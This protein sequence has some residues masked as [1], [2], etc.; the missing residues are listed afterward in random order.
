MRSQLHIPRDLHTRHAMSETPRSEVRFLTLVLILAERWTLIAAALVLATA[1]GLGLALLLPARYTA[2]VTILPPQQQNSMLTS[3]LASEFGGLSSLAS[4]A[5]GGLG[6]KNQND[7]YVSMFKSRIVEDALI[8]R[9]NLQAEYRKKYLSDARK[10]FEKRASVEGGQKDGLIHIAFE[11]H[12]PGRAAQIAN[13]YVDQFRTLSQHLAITEASQRR[14]FLQGQ[15]DQ[16]KQHLADAEEAMKNTEQKTGL[17]ALDSQARALIESAAYLR[18]QIAA[19]Q[20]QIEAMR[21]YATDQNAGLAQAQQELTALRAQMQKLTGSQDVDGMIVPRGQVTEAG[22]EY[23][24]KMR[25]VKYYETE[26]ALLSKQLELARL[27]EAREGSL[28]QIV[29]PASPPDKR[30]FPHR[31]L[32]VLAAACAGLFLGILIALLHARFQRMNA[33]PQTRSMMERIRMA[34]ARRQVPL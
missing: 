1:I 24:R 30:S 18:A 28:I 17:I 27:D 4:L 22:L 20:V 10:V 3:A 5:G 25:D 34:I 9:F 16:A 31:T 21:A 6:L 13:G 29:D 15:V 8:R 12:D 2:E 14:V 7:M 19:K 23:L 11:D 33:D 26:F 32:I